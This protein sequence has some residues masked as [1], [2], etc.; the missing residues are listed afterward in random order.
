MH[1]SFLL[2]AAMS[3]LR[4]WALQRLSAVY[5]L[6]FCAFVLLRFTF[7]RPPS[8]QAWQGWIASPPV[9]LA[10][11]LFFL[12]LSLHAWVG[13]RDVIMDYAHSIVLRMSL[14]SLLGL[15]MLTMVLWTLRILSSLPIT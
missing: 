10:T 4:A 6:V 9:A 7:N 12:A 1:R 11:A 2:K 15:G 5:L 8:F 3:G 13:L 14:F